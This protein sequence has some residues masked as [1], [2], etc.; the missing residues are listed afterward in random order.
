MLGVRLTSVMRREIAGEVVGDTV[1]LLE[2]ALNLARGGAGEKKARGKG[3]MMVPASPVKTD[4]GAVAVS[5]EL[6][7]VLKLFVSRHLVL[8]E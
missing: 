8:N 1:S 6:M 7:A 3:L 4:A 5:A 2:K